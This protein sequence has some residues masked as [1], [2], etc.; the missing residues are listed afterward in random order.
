MFFLPGILAL[1]YAGYDYAGDS[2]RIH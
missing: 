2:W 1:M